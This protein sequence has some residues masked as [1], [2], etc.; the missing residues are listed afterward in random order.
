MEQGGRCVFLQHLKKRMGGIRL[1]DVA[2]G[3]VEDILHKSEHLEGF[4]GVR[5]VTRAQEHQVLLPR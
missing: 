3:T 5:R 1:G 2:R 4:W